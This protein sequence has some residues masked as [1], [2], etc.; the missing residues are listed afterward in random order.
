MKFLVSLFSLFL[1]FACPAHADVRLPKL[2]ASHMVLQ[3]NKPIPVWGWADA[4]EKVT[5]ALKGFTA[6]RQE[7]AIKAG[8]DEMD[9]LPGC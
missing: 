5:V 2:F 1:L 3:R 6:K 8:K 7:K 4:G 9:N